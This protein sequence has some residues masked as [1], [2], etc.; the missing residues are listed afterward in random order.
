MTPCM[1][2]FSD[3]NETQARIYLH[4]DGYPEAVLADFDRFFAA[5]EAQTNGSDRRFH[6]PSLLATRFV[7]WKAAEMQ[8][9]PRPVMRAEAAERLR[10]KEELSPEEIAAG[11]DMVTPA[12]LD[13]L[14]IYIVDR[15][16]YARHVYTVEC[17]GQHRD[18]ATRPTVHHTE[19]T[20]QRLDRA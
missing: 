1:I 6:D 11:F 16:L 5:V 12:P 13:F 10:A 9:R 8:A 7:V 18:G 19:E 15:D 3:G 2:H 14:S 20:T 17:S 4:T